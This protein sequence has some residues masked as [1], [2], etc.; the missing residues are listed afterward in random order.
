MKPSPVPPTH[1]GTGLLAAKKITFSRVAWIF[2][3]EALTNFQKYPWHLHY[4]M[5]ICQKVILLPAAKCVEGDRHV[6]DGE[7][8]GLGLDVGCGDE[9]SVTSSRACEWH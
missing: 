2:S 4:R 1:I 7:G 3:M 6:G 5:L 9:G 8:K